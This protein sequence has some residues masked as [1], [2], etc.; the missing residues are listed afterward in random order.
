MRFVS[1]MWGG[2]GG[3]V[4][5]WMDFIVWSCYVDGDLHFVCPCRFICTCVYTARLF[6]DGLSVFVV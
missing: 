2:V 3:L 6:N 5:I 4:A 1:A